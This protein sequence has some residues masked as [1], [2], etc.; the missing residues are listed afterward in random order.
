MGSDQDGQRELSPSTLFDQGRTGRPGEAVDGNG[1]G[2]TP[3]IPHFRFKRH[4]F[5]N[6]IWVN[7]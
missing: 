1:D 7:P 3:Y 6:Q 2:L 5:P 4:F